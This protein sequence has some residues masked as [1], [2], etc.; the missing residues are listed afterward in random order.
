M[1]ETIFEALRDDHQTQRTLADLLVKTHGDSEGRD[2]LF[3]KLKS[4][5]Q[6]HAAAEERCFYKPLIDHD[7][8]QEKAR[9]GIAE[10]HE[11]DELIETLEETDPSSPAWKAHA[12]NLQH[13][14]HH[15]L[16]EEEQEIFQQAGRVLSDDLKASLASEY[17]KQMNA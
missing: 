7:L 17:R 11:I 5:L 15:H 4:E 1:S 16:D 9:H 14:V 10:H 6:R 2:E 13:M 12:K 8:T 3:G